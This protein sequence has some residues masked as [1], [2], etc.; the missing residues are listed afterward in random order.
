MYSCGPSLHPAE[1]SPQ[2]CRTRRTSAPASRFSSPS[3][4]TGGRESTS[5]SP[6]RRPPP[7]GV[8]A[9]QRPVSESRKYCFLPPASICVVNASGRL[10]QSSAVQ[11]PP[12]ML[13]AL[14]APKA[15]YLY[16]AS[17]EPARHR[18]Y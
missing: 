13:T 16:R 17:T 5:H 8:K 10:V 14:T 7:S 15:V 1:G 6:E 18:G 2:K 11:A 9:R 12:A 3:S 4:F